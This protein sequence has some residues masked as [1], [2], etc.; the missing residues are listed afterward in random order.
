L[1]TGGYAGIGFHLSRL[2]Y[3]NNATLYLAGRSKAKALAAIEQLRTACP[4]SKGRIEFL[5]LDLSDLNTIKPCVQQFLK[6]ES[7]LDV[8]VNNAAIM[9]PPSGS[10]SAQGYDLQ[11]ATNVYGPFLFSILL[12][13]ILT[14]TAQKAETGSVRIVWCASH[15]PDL[16]GPPGGV[17][18]VPDT[19]FGKKDALMIKEDWK[20]GPS[21]AQS[22]AAD[23]VLATECARRWPS[24]FSPFSHPPLIHNILTVHQI[25]YPHP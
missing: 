13:P 22:K 2:L 3:S 17:T 1:I 8:L 15:A 5:Y 24:T 6:K 11:T 7:R 10:K 14:A 12:H 21:Y 9:V 4:G 25:S 18:F 20:G 16:F 23:I 19:V